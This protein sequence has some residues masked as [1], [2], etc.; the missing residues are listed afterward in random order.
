MMMMMIMIMIYLDK[1][2]NLG[3]CNARSQQVDMGFH[4]DTILT[5]IKPVFFLFLNV[6]RLEEKQQQIPMIL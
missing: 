6:V 4:K 3:F 1:H 2:Y 5:P